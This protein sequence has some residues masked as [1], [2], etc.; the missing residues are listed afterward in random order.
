MLG[1]VV[2]GE[3][4]IWF[5]LLLTVFRGFSPVTFV[6]CDVVVPMLSMSWILVIERH[7]LFS[8]LDSNLDVPDENIFFSCSLT[9]NFLSNSDRNRLSLLNSVLPYLNRLFALVIKQYCS[10]KSFCDIKTINNADYIDFIKI[11][12]IATFLK[13]KF[14]NETLQSIMQNTLIYRDNDVCI[15]RPTTFEESKIIGEPICCFAYNQNGW[16]EH[17]IGNEE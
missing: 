12:K 5:V 14:D 11:L 4:V 15:F 10:V 2:V 8:S 1:C 17:Y 7:T 3:L 16:D 6:G 9:I 13:S